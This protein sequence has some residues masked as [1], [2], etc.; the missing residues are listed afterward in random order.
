MLALYTR[1]LCTRALYTRALYT[2]TIISAGAAWSL[3]SLCAVCF[4]FCDFAYLSSMQSH[5]ISLMNVTVTPLSVRIEFQKLVEMNVFCI[6]HLLWPP[7]V[8]F[9]V[10]HEQSIID[11][12]YCLVE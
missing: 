4:C 7:A 9:Q 11:Q 12:H 1:A 8:K 6:S 2:R 3:Y 5:S 10:V